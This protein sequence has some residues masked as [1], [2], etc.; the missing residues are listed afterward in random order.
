MPRALW[1]VLLAICA[2]HA[3]FASLVSVGYTAVYGLSRWTLK[4]DTTAIFPF[5]VLINLV[6]WVGYALWT[7]VIFWLGRRFPFDRRGWKRAAAVHVPASIVITSLHLL[8]V[9]TWRYYLQGVRGG[10]P[11][12]ITTVADAFFRTVDQ[13]LP[14]YWAA[15]G[16]QHALDYSRQARERE[17]SEEH[18]SELQSQ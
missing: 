7:P 16:L 6:T 10:D 1:L 11:V 4:P 2:A 8:L 5:L 9:A 17:R 14:V 12:W 15:I 3:V 13:Q 18:T